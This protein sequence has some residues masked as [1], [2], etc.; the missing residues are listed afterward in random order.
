MPFDHRRIRL[1]AG[2]PL[3]D[4][5]EVALAPGQVHYL[6]SVMRRG[7]G[8][9]VY[10]FNARD[11]EWRARIA[12]TGRRDL[13]A[14]CEARVRPPE[15]EPDLWL[16]FAPLKR[17]PIDNL[18][19]KATELGVSVLQ[20]V[21]TARTVAGRVNLDRLRAHAVEAAEQSDRLGV[22]E[23]RAPCRLDELLDAWPDDRRVL[24]CDES[25][26]GRPVV[27]VLGEAGAGRWAVLTGPEGGFTPA[28]LDRLRKHP[29]V[30][31][32]SLGRR[33]LRADTA[34]IAA[35]V[36]IQAVVGDWRGGRPR[37]GAAD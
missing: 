8:D 13:R 4:G 2:T 7:D 23:V 14:R 29:I 10:L 21:V 28:E 5:A 22:P 20:P 32:A 31:A 12:A 11:G 9:E 3:G 18:A 26:A 27:E 19:E 36:C 24:L 25:G 37:A 35:L 1:H 17:G 6:R 34:A 15:P 33:I 16:A 30:T